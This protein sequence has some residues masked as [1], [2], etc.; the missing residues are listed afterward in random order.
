VSR[1][2]KGRDVI[3]VLPILTNMALGAFVSAVVDDRDRPGAWAGL[4]RMMEHKILRD[5]TRPARGQPTHQIPDI[6]KARKSSF[7]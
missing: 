1:S 6:L 7:T 4:S 3:A 2:R 5:H